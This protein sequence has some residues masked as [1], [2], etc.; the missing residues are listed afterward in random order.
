M[1]HILLG[2]DTLP[3][4]TPP[5]R[6]H[7]KSE[8]TVHADMKGLNF[9]KNLEVTFL[10]NIGGFIGSDA[11]CAIL[12]AGIYRSRD[13]KIVIDIGTNGEIIVGNTNRILTASTAAGPALGARYIKN[14][15]PA[16]KGAIT[17][18]R[19]KKGHVELDVMG[20]V[21]PKGITGL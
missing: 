21:E 7:Q 17:G 16:I 11:L 4:I 15:M 8:M 19:I 10:P 13:L 2:I 3:L 12:A 14:G 20:N 9:G 6:I 5:Y 18:V 1:H